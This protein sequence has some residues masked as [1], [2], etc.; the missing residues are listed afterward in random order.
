MYASP[1]A[2]H[3]LSAYPIENAYRQVALQLAYRQRESAYP[4]GHARQTVH[5][6]VATLSA[7]ATQILSRATQ[8]LLPATQILVRATQMVAFRATQMVV[9]APQTRTRMFVGHDLDADNLALL[10]EHEISVV[11][12]RDLRADMRAACRVVMQAHRVLPQSAAPPPSQVQIIT[13]F[14]L[15]GA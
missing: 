1:G 12:H 6:Q 15:P 5:P 7:P 4:P 13:P 3:P 11:L 10:R 9:G 2:A 8:K 14:N